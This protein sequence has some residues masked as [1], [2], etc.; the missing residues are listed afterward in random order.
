MFLLLI[1]L[2]SLFAQNKINIETQT[3][4]TLS[5]TRVVGGS[6][7]FSTINSPTSNLPVIGIGDTPSSVNYLQ[8]SGAISGSPIG[9]SAV[10]ANTD[11]GISLVPKGS[12]KVSV[13]AGSLLISGGTGCLQSNGSVMSFTACGGGGGS[14]DFVGPTG[15][16]VDSQLVLFNGTT[17]KLGKAATFSGLVATSSGVAFAATAS[18]LPNHASR[19]QDGG[20]DEVATATP[21]ANAIVKA[22]SGGAIAAGWLPPV[23][24]VIGSYGSAGNSVSMTVDT[25]GR[26]TAAS[27]VVIQLNGN[28]I[29]SG[30]IDDARLPTVM[31]QKTFN[32]GIYMEGAGMTNE[33]IR[34]K[35]FS[36]GS[37][38]G[39][40][41]GYT[42]IFAGAVGILQYCRETDA[43]ERIGNVFALTSTVGY[44]PYFVGNNTL[45][46]AAPFGQSATAFSLLQRGIN[47]ELNA[48][49]GK[50]TQLSVTSDGSISTF[51]RFNSGT[52]ILWFMT[53]SG[54]LLSYIDANGKFNGQTLTT[55]QFTNT[56]SVCTSTGGYSKGISAV[57]NAQCSAIDLS[58]ANVT[59][60]LPLAKGGTGASSWTAG[61]C[62]RVNNSGTALEVSGTDCGTGGGGGISGPGTTTINNLARW[63]VMNGTALDNG[64]AYA[65]NPASSS[66]VQRGA[67]GDGQ[68]TFLNLYATSDVH[69]LAARR[70]SSG[71]A[72]RIASF[73]TETS[74]E[75]SAI[76][77]LG[78]FTGKAATA[79]ALAVDPSA[80]PGGQFVTDL[81]AN[82]TLTCSS[83]PGG[84]SGPGSSLAG[85]VATF[86]DTS[87]A[88]LAASTVASTTATA[89]AFMQRDAN[90]AAKAWDKGAQVINCK[91]FGAAGDGS[92][93]DRSAIQACIDA[94][95]LGGGI[96][97]L[98]DGDFNIAT[99]HPSYTGCGLVLGNGTSSAY[100]TVNGIRLI[101]LNRGSSLGL[102][103]DVN[104][105]NGATR[106]KANGTVTKLIC[107]VGPV[108]NVWLE[109]LQL[110]GQ[111]SAQRLVDWMHGATG[112]MRRVGMRNFSS[113]AVYMDTRVFTGSPNTS[114][115]AFF[116]CN[117]HFTDVQISEPT[118]TT[119]SA[120]YVGGQY[121]SGG[122]TRPATSNSSCSNIFDNVSGQ[123][124]T[125][126]S[127][128]GFLI[129]RAD[130]NYFYHTVMNSY[131]GG[132]GPGSGIPFRGQQQSPDT[133][134]P[135]A[136]K[137]VYNP[138]NHGTVFGGTWT[139]ATGSF[140]N[141]VFAT[142]AE[143]NSAPNIAGMFWLSDKG[144]VALNGNS[145]SGT[146]DYIQAFDAAN[147]KLSGFGRTNNTEGSGNGIRITSFDEIFHNAS[148]GTKPSSDRTLSQI[149]ASSPKN[150]YVFYCSDCTHGSNPCT[151]GGS[152]AVLK[153]LNSVNVCN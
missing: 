59:S 93:N 33:F 116:S 23:V 13:A 64:L 50:L 79:T 46:A 135:Y 129:A 65:T 28:Q 31:G 35:T 110:D 150:G 141:F 82:G 111:S 153:R 45:Q 63:S 69:T 103:S 126:S 54:S 43:V 136:N 146:D 10:G 95:P 18:D 121:D 105:V 128:S 51:K 15:P 39:C 109:D 90:G 98:P 9:L 140:P 139:S 149:N 75:V 84:I 124:G 81:A 117:N 113:W 134:F 87:G 85:Q 143:G 112:G 114:N 137:F 94:L 24:G 25:Y 60:T 83:P 53:E 4:G 123:F 37:S 104:A 26:I 144:R 89:N 7:R 107:V 131:F 106:I 76:D 151:S 100:S 145:N 52:S 99:D 6:P 68:Y 21:G 14:G 3:K 86:N 27:S 47:G 92:T 5:G 120:W 48:N 108:V 91:A 67:A 71:Q 8:I 34:F 36:S 66:I 138:S 42:T 148:G 70:F 1:L 118:A 57:G 74:T 11:I 72:S 19:H 2:P 142:E 152:G 147:T 119:A 30:T 102:T 56:P 58:T 55:D 127:A 125:D 22:G 96:A 12:G 78:N 40:I 115:W 62:V 49:E 32:N 77:A 122:G 38:P 130:N 132:G 41:T 17:G 20:A 73:Q 44:I 101:G 80:C 133:L 61:K 29:T 88:H 16:V 97:Y